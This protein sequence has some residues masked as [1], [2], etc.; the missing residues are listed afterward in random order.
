MDFI[1]RLIFGVVLTV[2]GVMLMRHNYQLTQLFGYNSYA[3]RY[4]GSGGTYSM[5]KLIGLALVIG[6]IIY[7]F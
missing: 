4:L 1:V 6:S 3:E 5:W 7:V 2:V